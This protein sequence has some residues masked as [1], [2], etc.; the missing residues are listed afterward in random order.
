MESVVLGPWPLIKFGGLTLPTYYVVIS[1]VLMVTTLF[2]AKRA[3][4]KKYSGSLALDMYLSILSAGVVGARVFHVL[5]EAP[6]FYFH[7][8]LEILYFWQGG[9]VFYGGVLGGL[10]G[11]WL[12]VNGE[13][14]YGTRPWK[15]FGEGPTDIPEGAFTDT[16]RADFISHEERKVSKVR[17]ALVQQRHLCLK[18]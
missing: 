10:L 6:A 11:A 8:P 7:N 1:A 3:D 16:H 18:V 13:A 2:V 12:T 14:I 15:V 9:F 4:Q 5:Y 17:S